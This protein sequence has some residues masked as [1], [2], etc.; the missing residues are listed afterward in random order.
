M[1]LKSIVALV[2]APLVASRTSPGPSCR[3]DHSFNTKF[4]IEG[5]DTFTKYPSTYPFENEAVVPDLTALPVSTPSRTYDE[6]D[7]GGYVYTGLQTDL[8]E[9]GFPFSMIDAT[10][11]VEYTLVFQYDA[12]AILPRDEWNCT[13]KQT[14]FEVADFFGNLGGYDIC[15]AG[16]CC[17]HLIGL[18]K[19][20]P[21]SEQAAM[22]TYYSTVS[23]TGLCEAMTV[24]KYCLMVA[25]HTQWN[26]YERFIDPGT[27]LFLA[28]CPDVAARYW[29][30]CKLF[31]NVAIENQGT[32]IIMEPAGYLAQMTAEG[33]LIYT[34]FTLAPD[35]VCHP[36]SY[37]FPDAAGNDSSD[38][39]D[40]SGSAS[41]SSSSGSSSSD[42]NSNEDSSSALSIVVSLYSFA[43]LM[44]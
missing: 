40:S 35:R 37:Y 19:Y 1:A 7:T 33:N 12:P 24:P 22:H 6:A 42:N 26:C 17:D 3:Q 4:W 15:S 30:S 20:F 25:T 32:Q 2:F 28:C 8:N 36:Y 31:K 16:E 34:A 11:W 38:S 39:S 18:P 44:F 21:S 23:D 13:R 43:A 9:C 27:R 10:P 29:L 5:Q 14:V 41:G